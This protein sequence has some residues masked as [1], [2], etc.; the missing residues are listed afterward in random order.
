MGLSHTFTSVVDEDGKVPIITYK[1]GMT[2]N[3]MDY[4]NLERICL[5]YWQCKNINENILFK[6]SL[7]WE[8]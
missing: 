7:Q 5:Y 3:I 4:T 2:D 6:R 8:E 1:Q